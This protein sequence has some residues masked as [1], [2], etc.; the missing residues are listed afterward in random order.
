VIRPAAI[1]LAVVA[2]AGSAGALEV[3]PLLGRLDRAA[4][5]V[6]TLSGE[7]TQKSRIKLFKQELSSTG[8][9][10][11]ERPRRVRWE[12]LR[13]DASTLILDGDQATLRAEGGP[14]QTFDLAKDAAMRAVFDQLTLW[15]GGGGLAGARASYDVAAAGSEAE[16]VLVLSPKPGTA[17][18]KTF[19]R[20]ELR[21][22]RR[23]LL[24]SILLREVSGDEKEI[25]FT[26]M[27]RDV[28]LPPDEFK[29]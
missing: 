4:S 21:F 5:Q 6:R 3:D 14:P 22:D 13:P 12:Y 11:F 2:L 19:A 24:R 1:A 28:K 26:K 23:L 25:T 18:A 9:M 27:E 15:L 8:R 20:I 10:A 29:R 16:P 17:A 7:F